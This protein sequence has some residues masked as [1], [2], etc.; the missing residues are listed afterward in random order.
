MFL[1]KGL[2]EVDDGVEVYF[3][4]LFIN[5]IYIEVVEVMMEF[6]ERFMS[7][8]DKNMISE[9]QVKEGLQ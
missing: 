1:W 9:S 3:I 5:Q 4:H 7:P 2:P 6:D 8:Y